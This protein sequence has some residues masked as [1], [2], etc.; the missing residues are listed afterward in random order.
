MDNTSSKDLYEYLKKEMSEGK[1]DFSFRA[2]PTETGID[3]TIHPDSANGETIDFSL[4]EI[5]DEISLSVKNKTE[6]NKSFKIIINTVEHII[7]HS[8]RKLHYEDIITLAE[9]PPS[10][11]YSVTYRVKLRG[12]AS[13]SRNGILNND[14]S[15]EICEGMTFNVAFIP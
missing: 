4:S 3:I 13:M 9:L 10:K 5:G 7:S 11:G 14:Q 12:D 15:V 1:I 6:W 2:V 8:R